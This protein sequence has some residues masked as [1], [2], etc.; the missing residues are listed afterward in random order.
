MPP[1]IR[2]AS[3]AE[4]DAVGR[5]TVEAYVGAGV[6]PAD[7]PYLQFLG[8]A[9]HRDAHAELWVAVD[10]AEWR[11][12]IPDITTWFERFGDKLPTVLWTELDGLKARLGT[13]PLPKP[14]VSATPSTGPSETIKARTADQDICS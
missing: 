7:A 5:L 3:P 8:D 11:A 1:T 10:D 14:T 4:L 6:I 2:R 9:G 12:E 13:Q